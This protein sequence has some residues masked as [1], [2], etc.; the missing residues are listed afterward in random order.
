MAE[1]L[2]YLPLVNP[3]TTES[4]T[5]AYYYVNGYNGNS[6]TD[7]KAL[8]NFETYGVL[9]N[10]PAAMDGASSSTA[11]PSGIQ[12]VCP[13]G[14]HLPSDAEWSVLTNY[15]G[16]A[17]L[18]GGHLKESTLVH[19]RSPNTDADNSAGFTALPG[20]YRVNNG[21]FNDV[22]SNAFF[23]SSTQNNTNDGKGRWIMYNSARIDN[24]SLYYKE[25]GFSV[26]AQKLRIFDNF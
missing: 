19:W 22:G 26:C 23:W 10:W 12:G 17:S 1:N 16:G 7:A 20:G 2:A 9:Y 24:G 13:S 21:T 6:V 11:S 14:W 3:P 15:L 5:T 25:Y 8:A 4:Y 18:A